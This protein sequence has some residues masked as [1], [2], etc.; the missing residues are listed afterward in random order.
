MPFM[1]KY[2]LA[3]DTATEYCSVALSGGPE[4]IAESVHC[5]NQHA[6]Q[7]LGMIDAL[8]L[9]GQ[10]SLQQLDGIAFGCGPGSFTGVRIATAIAQGLA[11]GIGAPVF[12]ISTLQIMAQRANMKFGVKRALVAL[13]ARMQQIYWGCYALD[14]NGLMRLCGAQAVLA[15]IDAQAPLEFSNAAA[16]GNGWQYQD[17]FSDH[18]IS[19]VETIYQEVYPDA[20]AAL[21]LA[22]EMLQQEQGIDPTQAMAIYLRDNVA[23]EK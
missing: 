7:L 19:A 6:A 11:Y 22:I 20:S 16:V 13:D 4:F 3:L 17:L 18:T 8:L 5:K 12:P 9:K 15:P 1:N 10:I 2:I 21:P 14:E 23:Q